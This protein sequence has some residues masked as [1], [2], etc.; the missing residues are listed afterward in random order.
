MD[1]TPFRLLTLLVAFILPAASGDAAEARAAGDDRSKYVED[2]EFIK[3]TVAEKYPCLKSKKIDWEE[4]TAR[5]RP[6]FEECGSDV[7]HVGNVMQLLATLRDGHSVVTRTCVDRKRL[8][9]KWSGHSGG[10]LWIGWDDGLLVLRGAWDGHSLLKTV[11]PGSIIAAIDGEPAW[12]AVERE[13][14]RICTWRGHSSDHSLFASIGATFFQFGDREE[15]DILFITPQLKTETFRLHRKSPEGK[16]F[17]SMRATLPEGVE[18]EK[19]AVSAFLASD[20]CRKIGYLRITGSMDFWTNMAFHRAVDEL[21]GMEA[22]LLDCRNMGGGADKYAR[23]MAGRFFSDGAENGTAPPIGAS[24]FWQFD[25]PVVMLQ[26]ENQVSSAETFTLA[27]SETRRVISVGRSTGGWAIVPDD[28]DCP[29]GLATFFLGVTDRPTPIG[30]I[31]TEGAGWPPDIPVPYGPVFCARLD[32]A[33]EVGLEILGVLHAGAP[34]DK[35][36]EAFAA[37]FEGRIDEFLEQAPMLAEGM[38]GWKPEPLANRV[39]RDLET[40]LAMETALLELGGPLPSDALGVTRRL[41]DLAPRARAAG[42][43]K[44]LDRLE[45]AVRESEE[46]CAAQKSFLGITDASLE[47][48]AASRKV[49]QNRFGETR[50][51]RYVSSHLWR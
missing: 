35:V 13:K 4:I 11:P 47:A 5:F 31:R 49:F 28:F 34:R 40:R 15:M 36:A 12:I 19:G 1:R 26:N 50:T 24:G 46:E 9:S 29:S 23:G 21:E 16:S 30:G 48:D 2:F 22:L 43:V 18:W 7:E 39:R 6:L 45:K 32:P 41:A 20:R 51:A 25:G 42:L 37:L 44:P 27:M 8:P 33:R 10:G 3:R 14:R 38:K 17:S